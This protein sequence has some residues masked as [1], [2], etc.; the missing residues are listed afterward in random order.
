[1][2]N[3]AKSHASE[4]KKRRE[5]IDAKNQGDQLVYQTEKQVKDNADKLDDGLKNKLEASVGRFKRSTQD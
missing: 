1:M 2:V 3:D 5:L 4:D